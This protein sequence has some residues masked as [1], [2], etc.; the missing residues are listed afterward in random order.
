M[1]D[2]SAM[3]VTFIKD[4]ASVVFLQGF[5]RLTLSRNIILKWL[6]I[7]RKTNVGMISNCF[8]NQSLYVEVWDCAREEKL[9]AV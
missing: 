5:A 7:L 3:K 2:N 8:N 9:L 6:F 4:L 1:P